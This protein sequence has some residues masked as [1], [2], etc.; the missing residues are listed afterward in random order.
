MWG[1]LWASSFL[2]CGRPGIQ[3]PSVS[4][5]RPPEDS[6]SLSVKGVEMAHSLLTTVTRQRQASLML[7]FHWRELPNPTQM[8][9]VG[10]TVVS[11]GHTNHFVLLLT[12]RIVKTTADL[13]HTA[14]PGWVPHQAL[15]GEGGQVQMLLGHLGQGPLQTCHALTR[16]LACV[17]LLST[18][19]L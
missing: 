15:P 18:L 5:L 13:S 17:I 14:L 9:R 10:G 4:S 7:R 6:L 3:P 11:D 2:L 12:P 1:F 19:S 16:D 8:Q